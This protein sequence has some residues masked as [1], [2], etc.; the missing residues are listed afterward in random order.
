MKLKVAVRISAGSESTEKAYAWVGSYLIK[1]Y[2]LQQ[3]RG[4]Q[5]P[6]GG[7][8]IITISFFPL[9]PQKSVPQGQRRN[10]LIMK[11]FHSH[12]HNTFFVRKDYNSDA[13]ME[14]IP[15]R[16]SSDVQKNSYRILKNVK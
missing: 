13:H 12:R 8:D 7:M 4:Q 10:D 5:L 16:A 6:K 1:E 11:I 3:I 9:A 2:C 15:T 14:I